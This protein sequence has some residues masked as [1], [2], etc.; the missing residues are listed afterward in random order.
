MYICESMAMFDCSFAPKKKT[1]LTFFIN[2]FSITFLVYIRQIV[3]V[4]FL[5]KLQ[6]IAI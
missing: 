3:T 2:T 6:R 1:K 5:Q 4:F